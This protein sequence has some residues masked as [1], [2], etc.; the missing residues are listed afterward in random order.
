MF[1]FSKAVCQPGSHPPRTG[2]IVGAMMTP[3]HAHLGERLRES[4]RAHGLTLAL[5][6]VPA[7]HRSISRRG[8]DDLRFTKANFVKF[9]FERYGWPVLYLDADCVIRQPTDRIGQLLAENVDFAIYNWLADEHTEAYVHADIEPRGRYYRFSHSIDQKSDSQLLCSGAVQWYNNTAAARALLD[10]WQEVQQCAPGS[11][12]DKCLDLAFNNLAPHSP[13]LKAVWLEKRYARYA[14]WIYERPVIDHPDMPTLTQDFIP[15][16]EMN[17]RPRI[18]SQELRQQTVAYMFPK[19]CLI[20]TETRTLLRLRDGVWRTVGSF[21]TPLWLAPHSAM[22]HSA[23]V[24]TE[25]KFREALTAHRESR[26]TE[27]AAAYRQVLEW[28]PRHAHALT[29]LSV[30]ALDASDYQGVLDLTRRAL[31]IDPRSAATHLMRGHALTRLGHFEAALESYERAIAEKA[32]SAD[33][34]IHRGQVLERLGRYLEA[35]ASYDRALEF[36][37]AGADIHNNRGNVLR[38]LRRYDGALASYERA[39]VLSPHLPELHFNR[40]LTLHD[41]KIHDAALAGFDRAIALNPHYAEAFYAR[42]NLLKDLERLDAALASYDAAIAANPTHADAFA[43]RGNVESAL[44]RFDAALASYDAAIT[45]APDRAE[46]H[47]NRGN[48]LGDLGRHHEALECIDRAIAIDPD[49]AQAHYSRAFVH[50]VLGDLDQGWQDFEWRWKNPHCASMRER[51]SFPQPR[52]LGEGSVEGK[53]LFVYCEQGL[54]DSIQF[55]RFLT[56]VAALGAKVILEVPK[57]LYRLFL[58]VNGVAHLVVRGDPLPPFDCFCPLLSLPLA[59]KITLAEVR[60]TVPYLAAHAERV[61]YWREKL[62]A[63][64]RPRVG[65]VWAGGSRP[66]QPELRAVNERRNIPLS[67]LASLKHSG[68][69][70]YSLQKGQPAEGELASLLA[71]RWDG[72]EIVDHTQELEDLEETAAL[73]EQLDLVIAVDTSTAHLAG[74]LGKP[75]WLLN[76]FDT[77]WRWMLDRSDSPWYPSLRLYRQATR[78]DWEGVVR[79]VR[80]DLEELG[81]SM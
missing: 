47:C 25:A 62:G 36:R 44:E 65:L 16:N 13:L 7:V 75:V 74:A 1:P 17:G 55:C 41:L 68:I 8:A 5:Y 52:W 53:T 59:L 24:L 30:I 6:E 71:A 66:D 43:N 77:C 21:S 63:R 69:E 72:P 26:L 31:D 64:T 14:W 58:S 49:H 2:Y 40:A 29:F 73:I 11:A 35:L 27:A 42:G 37:P 79:R 54:G 56:Q 9:L 70:F 23:E 18:A 39:I 67:R 12:D 34:H 33:A 4:C 50:L 10:A 20:D 22:A 32:D 51:R 80:A 3:S 45:I 60:M 15:L 78:G 48:L 46:V 61:T 81:G 38:S 76:R 19:E 28:Q 57:T